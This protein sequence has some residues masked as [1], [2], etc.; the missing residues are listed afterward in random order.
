MADD[1]ARAAERMAAEPA[2]AEAAIPRTFEA[3]LRELTDEENY[4]Q[5]HKIAWSAYADGDAVSPGEEHREFLFGIELILDGVQA[6]IDRTGR[7]RE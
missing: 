3:L 4:P 5:L 1:A 7:F 2:G 6:L